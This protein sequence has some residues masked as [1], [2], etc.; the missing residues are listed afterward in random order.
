MDKKWKIAYGVKCKEFRDIDREQ[1]DLYSIQDTALK[2]DVGTFKDQMD[3]NLD[4]QWIDRPKKG[5]LALSDSFFLK[6]Q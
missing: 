4:K 2:I 3:K 6:A 5:V 1:E